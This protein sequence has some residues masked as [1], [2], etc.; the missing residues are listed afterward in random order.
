MAVSGADRRS[1]TDGRHAGAAVPS[2]PGRPERGG[3]VRGRGV[4]TSASSRGPRPGETASIADNTD[5]R[6]VHAQV[7]G[8]TVEADDSAASGPPAIEVATES[9]VVAETPG[10]THGG[11]RP[12]DDFG[13]ND[14][15]LRYLT[16]NASA[17]GR[18]V[19]AE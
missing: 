10:R 14:I 13:G 12:A 9:V 8:E 4:E 17:R 15:Y 18:A 11:D 3:S 19:I 1:D 6:G 7:L 16:A 2:S 5:K